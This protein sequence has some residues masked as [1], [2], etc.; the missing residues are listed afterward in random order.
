MV[1]YSKQSTVSSQQSTVFHA[2]TLRSKKVTK[3]TRKA[4]KNEELRT[5]GQWS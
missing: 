4:I 2:E 5:N 3:V 1:I